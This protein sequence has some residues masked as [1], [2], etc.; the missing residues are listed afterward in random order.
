M[1]KK[2]SALIHKMNPN[3]ELSKKDASIFISYKPNYK[4]SLISEVGL[5]YLYFYILV[6]L[7]HSCFNFTFLFYSYILVLIL[8]SCFTFTFLFY[9]YIL[10]LL[11]HSCF[12]FTFLYYSLVLHTLQ[13]VQQSQSQFLSVLLECRFWTIFLKL[14]L[15]HLALFLLLLDD[16]RTSENVSMQTSHYPW[17]P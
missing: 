6:L 8:H 7:L 2:A 11:L 13:S 3:L 10:V 5:L 17:W 1:L 9:F 14:F 4:N 12:T 15:I 16:W